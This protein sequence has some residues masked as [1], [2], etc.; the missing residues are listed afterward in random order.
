MRRQTH[1]QLN[2]LEFPLTLAGGL[3]STFDDLASTPL[4][5]RLATLMRCLSNECSEGE[6][7]HGASNT[8]TSNHIDRRGRR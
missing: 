6:P 4:P 8:E 3:R 5:A 1:R 2:T 7:G